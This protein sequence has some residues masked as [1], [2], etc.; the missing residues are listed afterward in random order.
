MVT[1]IKLELRLKRSFPLIKYLFIFIYIGTQILKKDWKSKR[2]R[3]QR[4]I[5]RLPL[6]NGRYKLYILRSFSCVGSQM[7]L[8]GRWISVMRQTLHLLL[9]IRLC[10]GALVLVDS[11]VDVR[12]CWW[13]AATKWLLHFTVVHQS[14]WVSGLRWCDQLLPTN[15]KFVV[16]HHCRCVYLSKDYRCISMMQQSTFNVSVCVGCVCCW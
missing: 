3:W 5:S 14:M 16:V 8:D 15:F 10:A 6:L 4:S 11:C 2:R 13:I 7:F 1:E 9:I 12:G